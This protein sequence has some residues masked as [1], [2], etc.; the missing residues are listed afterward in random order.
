MK[1]ISKKRKEKIDYLIRPKSHLFNGK[2][3]DDLDEVNHIIHLNNRSLTKKKKRFKYEM[4]KRFR[5]K[6]NQTFMNT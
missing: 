3:K 1:V 4:R 5:K 6:F 2:F